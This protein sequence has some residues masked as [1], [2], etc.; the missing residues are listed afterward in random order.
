[1]LVVE[2]L[3]LSSSCLSV[4]L[5]ARSLNV[6]MLCLNAHSFSDVCLSG[7]DVSPQRLRIHDTTEC[8]V[9]A[10][11]HCDAKCLTGA[12]LHM[13]SSHVQASTSLVRADAELS[14]YNKQVNNN[15]ITHPV[16]PDI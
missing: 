3:L 6:S 12:A 16:N 10:P 4:R 11:L 7:Y 8:V 1:M 13:S 14:A 9:C 5:S 15:H 2:L